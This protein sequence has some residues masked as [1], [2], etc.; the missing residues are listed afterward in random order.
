[1]SPVASSTRLWEEEEHCIDNAAGLLQVYSVAP[2]TYTI[3][4]YGRNQQLHGRAVPDRITTYIDSSV[5][6]DA[7]M[8]LI[9]LGTV[10]ADLF[11]IT[12]EMRGAGPAIALIAAQRF[13][14]SVGDVSA[15]AHPVIVHASIDPG[16]NVIEEELSAASEPQLAQSA[17]DLVKQRNFGFTGAHQRDAYI[18]VRFGN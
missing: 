8:S 18:N 7:Q 2:R 4:G 14:L 15:T 11:T 12:P 6:L 9:D 3:Y 16:G 5:A 1:M 10:N 17:L 13:A